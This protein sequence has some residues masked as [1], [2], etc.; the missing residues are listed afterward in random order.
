M[1][2]FLL[3]EPCNKKTGVL[4]LPVILLCRTDNLFFFSSLPT[5]FATLDIDGVR[6]II[7]ALPGKNN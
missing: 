6:K 2:S 3:E 4:N 7:F 1:T 5:T